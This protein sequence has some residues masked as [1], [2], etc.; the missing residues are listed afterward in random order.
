MERIGIM[1]GTG[2]GGNA[3]GGFAPKTAL[4]SLT[5]NHEYL[6]VAVKK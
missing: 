3:F 4:T 6:P 1:G 5:H 2:Y